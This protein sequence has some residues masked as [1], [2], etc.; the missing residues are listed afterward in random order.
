MTVLGLTVLTAAGAA[1]SAG[2]AAQCRAA[3]L[4][5]AGTMAQRML[6]CYER[7]RAGHPTLGCE[8]GAFDRLADTFQKVDAQGGCA[9]TGDAGVIGGLLPG[10]RLQCAIRT[11][12]QPA[13]APCASCCSGSCNTTT[14]TCD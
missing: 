12:L 7:D 9:V 1:G 3:K 13:G 6:L 10:A 8:S 2:P 5:A 4:R 11:L 14:M